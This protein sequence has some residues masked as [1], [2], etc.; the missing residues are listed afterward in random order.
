MTMRIAG[1][2]TSK[3]LRPPHV[4]GW[5]KF[6]LIPRRVCMWG[7]VALQIQLAPPAGW[8]QA[9]LDAGQ[10]AFGRALARY[11]VYGASH[12]TDSLNGEAPI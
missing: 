11:K 10:F 3:N 4:S 12:G 5:K 9:A 6:V 7:G 2:F 8:T 1:K